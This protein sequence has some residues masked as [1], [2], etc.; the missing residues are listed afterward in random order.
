DPQELRRRLEDVGLLD[1]DRLGR[2][3][4]H[5]PPEPARRA[6]EL[7]RLKTQVAGAEHRLVARLA[8]LP[9][10]RYP[11]DLPVVAAREELLAVLAAN[12]VVVVAGE[13]GSGKTTQL[14]KLC[15]ELGRGVRGRIGHTQPRRIAARSVAERIADELGVPLGTSVGYAVRFTDEVSDQTAIKVMT[16]GILL[17][18]IQRDRHLRQYDTIILDEAHERSLTIDFLLGYLRSVLASRPELK[19]IV[20]SATIDPGRFADFFGPDVPVVEVSGRTYPVEVRY[21]PL[22]DPDQAG[23]EP[24][25]Q[26]DGIV[27]AVHELTAEGPGDILVFLSGEREIRDTAEGLRGL[28]LPGTEVLPLYARL[29]AAEQHR[30]FTAHHGRRIV[31]ATNVAETSLTVPGIRYVIDPGTARISRYSARTRVQRLPIEAISQASARQRAGRCGRLSDGICIRLYS[32]EDYTSRP[33]FTDPEILRTSLASVL[34]SMAALDLGAIEDFA[35]LDPPDRRRIRDGIAVLEELGA[36]APA[37]PRGRDGQRGGGGDGGDGGDNSGGGRGRGLRLSDIGRRLARLTVDPR[38]ARMVLAGA[39]EGCLGEVLVLAAALS[40][41]DPRERPADN[42]AAASAAHA[43]F[44]DES[45]DFTA[46]LN[47]WTY[48][49]EQQDQLSG[50]AFRRLC[51]SEFLHFL[52]VREWQDL[53]GQLN[54]AVR[55]M[56]LRANREPAD[57]AAVHRA[58]L[59]GLLSHIGQRTGERRE[60]L[61]ARNARFVLAPGSALSARPPGWIMA[62]E[63]VE[64]SRLYARTAARTDPD[65]VERLAAH[66]VQRT[67]SEPR[68]D[69][70]RGAAVASERVTLYGLALVVGRTVPY[71]RV[72]PVVARELFVQHALVEGDWDTRHR[73]FATNQA[74]RA[75]VADVEDRLRRRDVVAGDE[76]IAHFYDERIPADVV[77]AR[78]FDTWWKAERR[79]DSDRLT[80]TREVLLREAAT[81]AEE[82]FPRRWTFGD[83]D[84]PATYRFAPGEADDGVTVHVPLDVLRRVDPDAATWPVPARREELV[85]A[86]L[87]S[88]PKELRRTLGPAPDRARAVVAALGE[89]YGALVD[90]VAEQLERQTGVR[91]RA[92]DFD[93]DRVPEHLRPLFAVD[94][95]GRTVA[96][97]RNLTELQHR[98]A[99]P[100]RTAVAD[101]TPDIERRGL[102]DWDFATLP[103]TVEHVRDGRR[104]LGYPALIDEGATVAIR[105]MATPEEQREATRAGLRRL[106]LLRQASGPPRAVLSS[107]GPRTRLAL[108]TNPDGSLADLVADAMTA[109]ID[110]VLDADP[111]PV[112]ERAD[113]DRLAAGVRVRADPG[114]RALL[115][116]TE[117]VLDVARELDLAL[118]PLAERIA[119]AATTTGALSRTAARGSAGTHLADPASADPAYADLLAQRRRLLG[120]RFLAAAGLRRVPHLARYLRAMLRRVERLPQERDIDAARA[121]RVAAVTEAYQQVHGR[122]APD[123]PEPA[124]L[125]A[126][127]W[128]IEEF[129]VSLWA[130]DLGTTGP[131]SEQRIF[132]A[133]DGIRI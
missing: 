132:R 6:A 88:L 91:M 36:L 122:L 31:L 105:V 102:S 73:F 116:E 127:R 82:D 17:A 47:L 41:Q 112:A 126:A 71:A 25:D 99:G 19:L 75:E 89:P 98:L 128:M 129:R 34:L 77:S 38:L 117:R 62:G 106:L 74:L 118:G 100:A 12:Q 92:G 56:G 26:I 32:E 66:L 96:R 11:S 49:R 48:L 110:D 27:A 5:L 50:N 35:F 13:T 103:A 130:Q 30:V 123:E 1:A 42:E 59:T 125:V 133:L 101:V 10:P 9:V 54:R 33:V 113:F 70:R 111:G 107:L 46:Y 3:L 20:T 83:L 121:A 86:L 16:D 28:E 79:R 58:L 8:A 57:Q 2:R 53:V 4:R 60:Y 61:G 80:L 21:R 120:P 68:W 52:R 51:R 40:I 22:V 7:G 15:L 131:V 45:S 108:S 69:R 95:G 14:P 78:H 63:L 114:L 124:G 97:S 90:A 76:V 87:R 64:T 119:A 39:D 29:S 93:L 43:R 84:L 115:A 23:T 67:Y 44:T 65:T 55:D 81:S 94:D 24:V 72:D 18:E 109:V 37:S 104:V 85:T